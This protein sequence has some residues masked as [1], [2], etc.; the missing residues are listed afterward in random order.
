MAAFVQNSIWLLP[1][2]Q[3][4]NFQFSLNYP[5]FLAISAFLIKN[6]QFQNILANLLNLLVYTSFD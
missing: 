2:K 1:S 5:L 3:I 6:L 4:G